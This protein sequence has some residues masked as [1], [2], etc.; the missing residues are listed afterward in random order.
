MKRKP[1]LNKHEIIGLLAP[2]LVFV[3]DLIIPLG[4]AV[5]VLYVCCIA[6]II[7][8][9]K[10]YIL[11]FSIVTSIFIIIVP[12][13][14]HSY[15]T[16]WMAFVNR[17]ISIIAIWIVTYV[18]LRHKNLDSKMKFYTSQL[19]KKNKELEQFT[20]IAS[21]DLQEPLRTLISFS[22][23]LSKEY[24]G[25]LD[26]K[27]NKSLSFISEAAIRMSTLV[28]D[29]LDYNRIGQTKEV[30]VVECNDIVKV[31]CKDLDSFIKESN[32]TITT[33]KL[34]KIKGYET[35]IRLLFQNL[36]TNAIKFRRKGHDPQVKISAR[37][38]PKHWE[39]SFQDNGIGIASKHQKKIFDIFKRLHLKHEY[40]GTGIG[41]AHC[42]K[43]V[44]LHQ[45]E[46]WVQSKPN[47]GSTFYFTLP[48]SI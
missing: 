43:I 3:I 41:L 2:S 31:V 40:A 22:D 24:Q 46:L 13:V 28:K 26:E 23:L 16:T 5:G 33:E 30:S 19:E 44:D 17:A 29:L 34:P 48:K 12:L 38:G 18:S 35:E 15:E 27:A 1:T 7:R 9:E 45:G 47:E 42:Q 36:I 37:V 14:T 11:F 32:A 21:H 20:Y 4:V 6:L 10:S 39:F 8:E 25:Q